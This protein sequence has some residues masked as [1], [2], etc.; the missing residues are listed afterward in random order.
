MLVVSKAA[1]TEVGN[2]YSEKQKPL[3][4]H[5]LRKDGIAVAT[6]LEIEDKILHST[7]I[8]L[9]LAPAGFQTILIPSS[10]ILMEFR[11]WGHPNL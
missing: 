2:P 3:S 7:C 6:P 8:P 11:N 9:T 5:Y 4:N 1:H 10:H